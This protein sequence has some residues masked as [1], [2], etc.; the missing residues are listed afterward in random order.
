MKSARSPEPA[1]RSEDSYKT[2]LQGVAISTALG[3][4]FWGLFHF[5]EK[6][7]STALPPGKEHLQIGRVSS[8][9]YSRRA[10]RSIVIY[11]VKVP[12]T[13]STV[14]MEER[15]IYARRNSCNKP[16]LEI[17][18]T[19]FL[20]TIATQER[21]TITSAH[22]LDGCVLQ[23]AALL[24]QMSAAHRRQGTIILLVCAAGILFFTVA[25]SLSWTRYKKSKS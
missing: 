22:T 13:N 17:G 8:E 24:E 12:S 14:R 1:P 15:T 11:K 10:D 2:Y 5:T 20:T 16:N 25:T 7:E 6:N 9:G 19:V 23:D 21:T 3:L 18:D 4:I